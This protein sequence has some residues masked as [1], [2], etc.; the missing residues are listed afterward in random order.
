MPDL[1]SRQAP[2]RLGVLVIHNDGIPEFEFRAVAPPGVHTVV[3]RF[4]SPRRRG[5]GY[6]YDV[7]KA[8]ATSEDLRR[9]AQMLGTMPLDCI[10]IAYVSGCLIA[11]MEW[12]RGVTAAVSGS[13]SGIPCF[14][15][16]TAM[17]AAC[18][19]LGLSS[20][21][22]VL[23][24]WFGEDLAQAARS[25]GS[26]AEIV[27]DDV[28]RVDMGDPWS[29]MAPHEIYDAGGGW[30]QNPGDVVRTVVGAI[31]DSADSVV[32]LG[33]GLRAAELIDSLEAELDRPVVTPQQALLWYAQLRYA[34]VPPS[35][36]GALFR[37]ARPRTG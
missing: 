30:A 10:G 16:A 5:S 36:P 32:V 31:K 2:L 34:Q 27:I 21:L 4:Q 14:G 28:V 13:A 8:F 23:P 3:A 9:S 12:D 22:A 33:S 20:P 37:T 15:T 11:G 25:F 17:V 18:Q 19:A 7:V 35:G 6:E 26:Q 1:S 24:A 29:T